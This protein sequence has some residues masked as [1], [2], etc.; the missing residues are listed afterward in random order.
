MASNG[1]REM[2]VNGTSSVPK[3]RGTDNGK[4][5]LV[6]VVPYEPDVFM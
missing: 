4:F 6:A 2:E 5:C 3:R 1:E